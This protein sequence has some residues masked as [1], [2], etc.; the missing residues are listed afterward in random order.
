MTRVKK[1]GI[2]VSLINKNNEKGWFYVE[3]VYSTRAVYNGG[4]SKNITVPKPI[5]KELERKGLKED[6]IKEADI[7]YDRDKG[8]MIVDFFANVHNQNLRDS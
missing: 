2:L 4:N 5:L 3:D 6:E 1:R 8:E 7:Y